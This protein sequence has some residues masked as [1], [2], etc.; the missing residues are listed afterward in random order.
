MR[1][2][3]YKIISEKL[4]QE[5]KSQASESALIIALQKCNMAYNLLGDLDL[6]TLADVA[7]LAI[8]QGRDSIA[9][10]IS[11]QAL[12][13]IHP[14]HSARVRFYC[15][16]LRAHYNLEEVDDAENYYKEAMTTINWHLGTSHPLHITLNGIY[17]YLLIP[18]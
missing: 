9:K 5:V 17:A 6:L 4:L 8:E 7:E 2:T 11:M 14:L 1:E 13:H 10:A 3:P 15:V 16:L 18:K 12:Q